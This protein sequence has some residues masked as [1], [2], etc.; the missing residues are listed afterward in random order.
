MTLSSRSR[1]ITRALSGRLANCGVKRRNSDA[2]CFSCATICC[3]RRMKIRLWAWTCF[4]NSANRDS[5]PDRY[6]ERTCA[7][8]QSCRRLRGFKREWSALTSCSTRLE[9]KTAD[10]GTAAPSE[11]LRLASICTVD[12]GSRPFGPT[13]ALGTLG[14]NLRLSSRW[15]FLK[16][17]LLEANAS[18]SFESD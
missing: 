11:Y 5:E 18:L 6:H 15:I 4:T 2:P 14:E 7:T 3:G 17:A 12:S 8:I 1:T 16:V 10:R 9:S 13:A